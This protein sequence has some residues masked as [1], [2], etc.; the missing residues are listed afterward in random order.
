[1]ILITYKKAFSFT[2]ND[3]H[4]NNVMY[5]QT[6]KKFI[7]YKCENKIYKVPT[8]GRLFKIIDFGRSIYTFHNKLFCSDSFNTGNEAATQYNTEPYFN[9]DKPRIEPN[10]SF[11]L[12]RF[13]CSIYDCVISSNE[14]NNIERIMKDPV[15]KIIHEWCLDDKGH[16]LMYKHNGDERYPDFKLYK[17]I[18]RHVHN[19]VPLKQ[20]ERPEFRNFLINKK[21]VTID[22]DIDKIPV[23]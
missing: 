3:L 17:M 12:C 2:H 5:I 10:P 1:M 18:A 6:N 16:N 14:M 21:N 22:I 15:K 9:S 13:A 19:H 7:Y 11:D 4:T 20:L 23:F 8:F